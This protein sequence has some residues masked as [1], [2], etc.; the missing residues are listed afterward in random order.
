MKRKFLFVTTAI[1]VVVIY[2]VIKMLLIENGTKSN[3]SNL[4]P[5][6][7]PIPIDKPWYSAIYSGIKISTPERLNTLKYTLSENQKS[8][9]SKLEAYQFTDN[10]LT[11]GIIYM[12]FNNANGGQYDFETGLKYAIENIVNKLNGGNL[13]LSF[14]GNQDMYNKKSYGTFNV[15]KTKMQFFQ[16]SHKNDSNEVGTITIY[17]PKNEAYDQIITKISSSIQYNF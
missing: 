11:V 16:F 10:Y 2:Y 4:S 12:K 13:T 3:V 7:M 14:I 17:A 6:K 15:N 1:M 9:M 8:F 5:V